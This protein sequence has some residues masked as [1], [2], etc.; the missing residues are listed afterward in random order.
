MKKKTI[1][2]L[3]AILLLFS[4]PLAIRAENYT[5]Q[6]LRTA[7]A[8]NHL[9]LFLGTGTSYELDEKL[10]RTQGIVLLV[11]LLGEEKEA[12]NGTYKTPFTDVPQWAEPYIGY[13]YTN[14]IT[15]GISETEFGEGQTMTDF[16]FITL[17]L[18][19]LGFKDSGTN[20]RYVWN[21]PYEFAKRAGLIN[22]TKEDKT[23]LRCDAITVFWNALSRENCKLGFALVDKGVFTEDQL[24]QAIEIH[25]YGRILSVDAPPAAETTTAAPSTTARP[26]GGLEE[27]PPVVTTPPA[28]SSKPETSK[29]VDTTPVPTPGQM[30]YEAYQA[31]DGTAQQ[32]FFESFSN[33]AD[34][35][36]WLNKA[37]AEYEAAN[38]SVEI[39]GNGNIDI[40]EL[41]GGQ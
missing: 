36:A 38:P 13:A 9:K 34:F 37:K 40:G 23:F 30:T 11:R 41:L 4:A 8:L 10:T 20:P 5:A 16:M 27:H 32:R 22:Y 3:T 31:L 15:N 6:Q 21:N 7:N 17:V 33:P 35:F 29:P 24:L 12:M 39:G 14:K 25:Q 18:R 19:A 26:N 28:T 1:A 2:L